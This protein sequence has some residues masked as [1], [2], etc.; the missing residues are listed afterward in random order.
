[1]PQ[2]QQPQHQSAAAAQAVPARLP[3]RTGDNPPEPASPP[4]PAG[5]NQTQR[6]GGADQHGGTCSARQHSSTIRDPRSPQEVARVDALVKAAEAAF[7]SSAMAERDAA[8][9]K[10]AKIRQ[11]EVSLGFVKRTLVSPHAPLPGAVIP[12]EPPDPAP[13]DGGL[14]PSL[15]GHSCGGA[16][17][18]NAAFSTDIAVG[19]DH[20]PSVTCQPD[21]AFDQLQ[22]CFT[23]DGVLSYGPWNLDDWRHADCNCGWANHS[24][25]PVML[26]NAIIS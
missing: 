12:L 18:E 21:Y 11:A 9:V 3:P 19:E 23:D 22:S 26:H 8:A 15:V 17:S 24:K 2:E 14:D 5:S 7:A 25:L 13:D 6:P 16:Y 4:P 10:A 20:L 1:M